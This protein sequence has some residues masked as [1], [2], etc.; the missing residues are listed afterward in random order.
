[1]S[2]KMQNI[3]I[4]DDDPLVC[5]LIRREMDSRGLGCSITT[6]PSE[7][8]R[9][10]ESHSIRVLVTDICMPTMSGLEILT[11]IQR[12]GI[13]CKTIIITGTPHVEYLAKSISLGAHDFMPKPCDF[14]I[15]AESI[16]R[17]MGQDSS[18]E[19][20]PIRAAKAIQKQTLVK[21]VSLE[22][23]LALARAVE[24]KDL[25]T[26]RHAEQVTYLSVNIA[27]EAGF[28]TELI[29][30]IRLAAM[31][32]DI[33]KIGIPDRILLKPGKLTEEE[34]E[35]IKTHPVV[36]AEILERISVFSDLAQ[37]VR[38][39]HENWNGTGYPDSLEGERLPLGAR[40]IRIADSIDAMFSA[41]SYKIPYTLE[42]VEEELQLGSGKMF[43]PQL[44][45]IAIQWCQS[46]PQCHDVSSLLSMEAASAR[47]II[48]QT[49]GSTNTLTA[50]N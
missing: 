25:Y 44:C 22:A 35:L 26:Q 48:E 33:G 50:G 8:I 13:D 12:N 37:F 28:D 27:K 43:D 6:D 32:H 19:S 4:V 24:A 5:G 14:N 29:E 17:A 2:E 15:L 34:F 11:Y 21:E 10:L 38:H 18:E 1:M 7:A 41:R 36:G 42:K 31:L 49:L 45:E 47:G 20:L 39:H 30:S 23:A 9:I 16:R 46:N 3:L 40:V